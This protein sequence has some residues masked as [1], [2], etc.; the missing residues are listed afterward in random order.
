MSLTTVEQVKMLAVGSVYDAPE[1]GFYIK[2]LG[3]ASLLP[4]IY[5]LG[6]DDLKEMIHNINKPFNCPN[7]GCIKGFHSK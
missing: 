2:L 6:S 7:E 3:G 5:Y 1:E 4:D